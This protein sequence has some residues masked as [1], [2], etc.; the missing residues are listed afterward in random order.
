MD[1]FWSTVLLA[2]TVSLIQ[3][4]GYSTIAEYV[5]NI[6]F[7]IFFYRSFQSQKAIFKELIKCRKEH[8]QISAQDEFAK[9]ARL[10]RRVDKLQSDY[11]SEK[12]KTKRW[13]MF[14]VFILSWIIRI[15]TMSGIVWKM[16]W[17]GM[18]IG[19]INVNQEM[20]GKTIYQLASYPIAPL[21]TMSQPI[22]FII[23][24]L[25]CK[26]FLSGIAGQKE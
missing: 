14:L 23:A 15:V 22:L 21:G 3:T 8:A 1:Y 25:G 5:Y 19:A 6:I 17:K 18:G 2:S 12:G 16:V 13:E 4:L 20:I 10:Q 11:D 26:R 9:W 24:T 7:Y